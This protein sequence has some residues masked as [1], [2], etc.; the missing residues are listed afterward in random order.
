[1]RYT[2]IC[3]CQPGEQLHSSQEP[4]DTRETT[5]R[6]SVSG[7]LLPPHTQL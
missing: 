5:G 6:H 2:T 7:T 3:H 1:M 4:T